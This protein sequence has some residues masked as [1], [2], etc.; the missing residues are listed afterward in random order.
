MVFDQRNRASLSL[1]KLLSPVW[2]CAIAEM[3]AW[4]P[5]MVMFSAIAHDIASGSKIPMTNLI[6]LAR[7]IGGI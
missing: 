6:D 1:I 5:L 4:L 7:S 2:L 3:I